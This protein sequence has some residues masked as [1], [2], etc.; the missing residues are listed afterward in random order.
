MGTEVK[1]RGKTQHITME[2]MQSMLTLRA[3][4]VHPKAI[5]DQFGFSSV[6]SVSRAFEGWDAGTSRLA[7]RKRLEEFEST[8]PLATA[9]DLAHKVVELRRLA[10]D[11]ALPE[12][13][14]EV[15]LLAERWLLEN[16]A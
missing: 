7:R 6:T 12:P 14:Q 3:E 15:V 8:T 2:E 16:E 9:R 4:G 10:T 11:R 5:A 13:L 1:R